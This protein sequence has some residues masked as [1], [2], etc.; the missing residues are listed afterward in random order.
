[1][2]T[3]TTSTAAAAKSAA[4][5]RPNLTRYIEVTGELSAVVKQYQGVLKR[6][7][8]GRPV[9]P[10]AFDALAKALNKAGDNFD[11]LTD[12][13]EDAVLEYVFGVTGE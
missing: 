2:T 10:K 6:I 12:K 7:A 8:A 1:M 13:H 9:D 11:K 5:R 4:R 3:K